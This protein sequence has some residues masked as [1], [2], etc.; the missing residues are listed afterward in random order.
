MRSS[1]PST[2]TIDF[3]LGPLNCLLCTENLLNSIQLW[4]VTKVS[5]CMPDWSGLDLLMTLVMTL[6]PIQYWIRT[7]TH[8]K[9]LNSNGLNL[10]KYSCP[11]TFITV[12]FKHFF[13][14][15]S[16]Y[17]EYMEHSAVC[18]VIHL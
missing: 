11:S 13:A 17:I 2:L 5:Q 16:T 15:Q 4:Y 6:F 12:T 1:P 7:V 3:R 14:T 18:K 9:N 10:N 8:S